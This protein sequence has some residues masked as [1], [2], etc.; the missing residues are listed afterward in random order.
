MADESQLVAL[1]KACEARE[2]EIVNRK[3]EVENVRLGRQQVVDG[4]ERDCQRLERKRSD[5]LNKDR[6]SAA[7]G[8]AASQIQGIVVYADKIRDEIES[9]KVVLAERRKDL[10]MAIAREKIVEEELLSARLETRRVEKLLEE[11][12]FQSLVHTSALDEV[13]VDELS[14]TIL[15]R[16]SE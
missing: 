7:R 5:L 14:S 4:L 2:L 12:N 6:I 9:A 13:T 8:S 10:E 11:R 1:Q 15:K 3:K 16:P